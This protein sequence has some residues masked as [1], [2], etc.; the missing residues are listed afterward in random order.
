MKFD[1][2]VIGGGKAGCEAAAHLLDAGLKVCLVSAGLTM[3][4]DG[5]DP[6]RENRGLA[7]RGVVVLRGDSAVSALL[8][9]GTVNAVF[10]EC[11]E[12]EPL[13]A[14][15]FVLA[16]G[17]FFSRGLLSDM[18]RIYEP[19]F[20][21]DVDYI[22]GRENWYNGDFSAAQPFLDFGV[23]TDAQGRVLIGGKSI[24]NLYATGDILAKGATEA[25]VVKIA[26]EYAGK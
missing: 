23:K 12:D 13:E 5:T 4:S 8:G 14:R 6:W 7:R 20:G 10:T 18:E 22:P 17:K 2:V 24:V 1:A 25:D 9:D 16:T 15:L 3:D 19:V 21:A 11:L 26:E